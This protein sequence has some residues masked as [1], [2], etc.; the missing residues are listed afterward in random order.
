MLVRDYIREKF[1][2]LGLPA[3]E[4]LIFE[5]GAILCEQGSN[6]EDDMTHQLVRTVNVAFVQQLPAVLLAPQSISELG[7]S[8]TMAKREDVI[9]YYRQQCKALGIKD[10]LGEVEA[11]EEAKKKPLIRVL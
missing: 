11:Q 6:L 9:S 3:V 2:L 7:V 1:Q 5:I 4:S 8:I 10:E